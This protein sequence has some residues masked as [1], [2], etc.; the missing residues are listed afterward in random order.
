MTYSPPW[1][2]CTLYVSVN[3]FVLSKNVHAL[4]RTRTDAHTSMF[5]KIIRMQLKSHMMRAC[6]T[7]TTNTRKYLLYYTWV[8]VGG[9]KK[10]I[11]QKRGG[12]GL[13]WCCHSLWSTDCR[14]Q[15]VKIRRLRRTDDWIRPDIDADYG[16][17]K[18]DSQRNVITSRRRR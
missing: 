2:H 9:E 10:S 8:H 18:D 17:D 15:R 1:R 6:I 7:Y 16:V 11:K 5:H 4:V 13:L 3:H 14:L 12:R